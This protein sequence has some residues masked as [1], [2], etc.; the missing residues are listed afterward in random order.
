MND[1]MKLK[2]C[3]AALLGSSFIFTIPDAQAV[4]FD[5]AKALSFAEKEICNTP[6]LGALDDELNLYFKKARTASGNSDDL[7]NFARSRFKLRGDCEDSECLINWY[8]ETLAVYQEVARVGNSYFVEHYDDPVVNPMLAAVSPDIKVSD[9]KIESDKNKLEPSGHKVFL[10]GAK[11]I[12]GPYD[13]ARHAPSIYEE[14]MIAAYECQDVK[15]RIVFLYD[16]GHYK[17]EIGRPAKSLDY[18]VN[19]FN[20]HQTNDPSVCDDDLRV[21]AL[22]ASEEYYLAQHDFDGD[23]IDEIILGGRHYPTGTEG[24]F[25]NGMLYIVSLTNNMM[26]SIVNP[27]GMDIC[28]DT[29]FEI[30]GNKIVL[31]RNLNNTGY[32]WSFNGRGFDLT[33]LN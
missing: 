6:K 2:T 17:L 16:H 32:E 14:L 13:A 9:Q 20:M 10:P 22:S 4:S 29:Q 30:T 27:V 11:I 1:F 24:E 25:T 8:Q 3:V 19:F 21:C 33:E 15:A 12:A 23:G 31:M 18:D 26:W 7:K 28:G 5:C